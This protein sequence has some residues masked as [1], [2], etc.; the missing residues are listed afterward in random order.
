MGQSEE[1][2]V[3]R[4]SKSAD[5]RSADHEISR[6]ELLESTVSHIKDVGKAMR[7]FAE[8]L[9]RRSY[10]HDYTKLTHFDE[11]Y[12]MFH[13]AQL[14]GEWKGE[15]YKGIHCKLER[16]HLADGE[17]EDVDLLDVIEQIC[18]G[19]MAGLARSGKYRYE[20]IPDGLLERA[21]GNTIRKLLSI[22]EVEK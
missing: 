21:Y 5:T 15:W 8:Q 12:E 22:V 14:T 20:D 2:I 3:I 4:E 6:D 19:V 17:P 9:E 13:N 7:W 16:H 11:F 10:E 18:D 1:K